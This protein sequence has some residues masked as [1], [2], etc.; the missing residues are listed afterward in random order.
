MT[1]RGAIV[2]EVEIGTTSETMTDGTETGIEIVIGTAIITVIEIGTGR[3]TVMY[4]I[5]I[6]IVIVIET[7]IG[8]ET[9]IAGIE[10][11]TE[12][13]KDT[14]IV[15]EGGV[16]VRV[17]EV[18]SGVIVKETEGLAQYLLIGRE[19]TSLSTCLSTIAILKC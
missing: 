19:G 13:E 14:V 5:E 17:A 8:T 7:E 18:E 11:A 3:K 16:L 1:G 2:T 10:A 15:T 4:M 12:S 9:I 6:E